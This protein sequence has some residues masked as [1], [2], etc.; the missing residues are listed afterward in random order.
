M[1]TLLFA[2]IFLLFI[3]E[4]ATSQIDYYVIDTTINLN[5]KSFVKLLITFGEDI[6]N[7]NLTI[8]GKI[9][10]FNATNQNKVSCRLK[11]DE[12]SNINCPTK[13]S[14]GETLTIS[15]ETLD[16]VKTFE[17]KYYFSADFSLGKDIKRLDAVIKIPE[18]MS[19]TGEIF[20]QDGK[21][22]SDGRR[23][24]V[25]WRKNN[26]TSTQA[27]K[28][29]FSYEQPT[30]S[31]SIL[32]TW[33]FIA[34]AVIA[35]LLPTYFVLRVGKKSERIVLSALDPFEKK[36]MEVI[37]SEGGRVNQK[38]VVQKTG[39]SKA[40]VSRLVNSLAKRNLITIERFGRT[41]I[42]KLKKEFLV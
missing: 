28:F 19:L 16:F 26:V 6:E 11:V 36:V 23:I 25:L 35:A 8:F 22:S 42:L 15:F 5:K 20:P 14:K 41:N 31:I 40:K 2:L 37:I 27:I 38:K 21:P 12:I 33:Q 13:I 34:V 24:M 39:L 29:H 7:F 3:G 9:E 1:K 10:K 32:P 4:V 30:P 18:G 17:N